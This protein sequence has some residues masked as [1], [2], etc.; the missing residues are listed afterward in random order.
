[1]RQLNSR[2]RALRVHEP[3]DAREWFD[4]L[5]TPDAH[6][7]GSDATFSRNGGRFHDGESDP[8][9][10]STA[11]MNEMPIVCQTVVGTV[12]AHWRHHDPIPKGD[13]S[14]RQRTEQVNVWYFPIMVDA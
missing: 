11:K 14:N 7:F 2:D 1:M 9:G 8:A 10:C 3:R 6:V 4:M 13:P 12:L 5:V